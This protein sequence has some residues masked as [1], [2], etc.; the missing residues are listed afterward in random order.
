MKKILVLLTAVLLI[1]SASYAQKRETREVSTFTKISFRTAGKLYVKQGSPQK[2]EIEGSAEML[3]KIKTKVEGG[4]LSIGPEEKWNNWN[5]SNDDKVTVWVTVANI[6]TMSVSG[7]G[8]LIAQTKITTSGN[9]NLNVSGSGSLTAEIEAGDVDSDVSGSGEIDIKG[10]FKNV[11]ADVSGS[12]QVSVN[13]TISGKADFE[14]SGSG[15]VSASGSA[16]SL[17]ADISGSGKVLGANLVTNT[18]KIDITG[19]GDV[20]ITVNKDLDADISGSGTVLYKGN[21]AHVNGN[22]SGSGSVKKM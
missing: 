17:S 11:S 14:I 2:V 22:A 6:E 18:A 1:A 12:G 15:K 13:G 3:E 4:K 16:E 10:K 5:W 8:D 19:S 9:M 21:P 7:S 20:E